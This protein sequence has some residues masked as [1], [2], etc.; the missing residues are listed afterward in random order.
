MGSMKLASARTNR[1]V[2]TAALARVGARWAARSQ[3]DHTT[4]GQMSG[5]SSGT[6]SSH[7]V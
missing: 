3:A 6:T 1:P 2:M 5:M 7:T 4:A